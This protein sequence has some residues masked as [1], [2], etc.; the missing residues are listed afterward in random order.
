VTDEWA[1]LT[2]TLRRAL[3]LAEQQHDYPEVMR[4]LAAAQ[5][6]GL[7]L[8]GALESRPVEERIAGLREAG[9]SYAAI[10]EA[11]GLNREN[12]RQTLRRH[13]HAQRAAA[14]RDAD[15]S[16]VTAE[17]SVDRL[18]LSV[19]MA[20]AFDREKITT[21][22]QVLALSP[23]TLMKF[24]NWGRVSTA[25]LQQDLARHGFKLAP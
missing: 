14:R 6:D 1:R 16:P 24:K 13:E 19:T 9:E 12:V 21:V 23:R 11:V 4:L 22:G 8:G 7:R 20:N 10:G 25:R 15:G 5:K 17:S 3:E 2:N 18:D